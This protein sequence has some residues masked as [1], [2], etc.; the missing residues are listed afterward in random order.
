MLAF[1]TGQYSNDPLFASEEFGYGGQ[2]LGRA[3]DTSEIAGDKGIAASLE[4]RYQM[5]HFNT[6]STSTE[7]YGFYDIG[8]TWNNDIGLTDNTELGASFGFG[9]RSIIKDFVVNFGLAW[10]LNTRITNSTINQGDR[11]TRL[12]LQITYK[13]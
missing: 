8:K 12:F 3:Y 6:N 9:S 1:V 7:L 4:L 13:F 10:P 5:P 2:F 11:N